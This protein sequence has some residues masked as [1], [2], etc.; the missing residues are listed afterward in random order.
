MGQIRRVIV[1]VLDSVGI[2]E[3]PDATQYGDVGSNTLGNLARA[4]PDFRLPHLQSLGLGN[5]APLNGVP[6]VDSPHASYGKMAERSAGKDTT[7]GH[8]ELMGAPLEQPFPVYPHGFPP[9]VLDAFTQRIGREILG[10][11]PA[12]GTQIIADLGAEH[13]AT[14]KPIVYTSADSVFQIA[15]HEEIIPIEQLYWMCAQAR[16]ILR[17]PHGVGRVIARPFIGQPGH[18]TRTSRRKDFSLTPPVPTVLDRAKAA[19]YAV[20]GVG[21]IDNI[22]AD[23]G[24]TGGRHTTNNQDGIAATLEFMRSQPDGILLT[25]LGDFDTLFG[26]RNDVAG[27]AQALREFDAHVPDLL[28]ACQP[29]DMLVITADHGCDPTTPSTDHSREYVPLLVYGPAL[30]AGID[31][32]I[33]ATFADVA[34][35]I[36]D[37]LRLSTSVQ[38]TSFA[39]LVFPGNTVP[40]FIYH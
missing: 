38:G 36:A 20:S 39:P 11:I 3:L 28:S 34:A 31:L 19:G 7:T 17:G 35:T 5:I 25:N 6:P 23:Q 22:F 29:P 26:H 24:L 32:G 8:W 18:F 2:G 16:E 4:I 33:R 10:N 14:G 40:L 21:K 37:L 13:V 27:Y 30:Q 12:S 15:A 1:I 9:E